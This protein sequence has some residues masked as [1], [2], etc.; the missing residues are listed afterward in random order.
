MKK[1][2]TLL[3]ACAAMCLNSGCA[4][5]ILGGAAGALGAYAISKDTIEGESDRP[6]KSLW[7]AAYKVSKIR[8]TISQEDDTRGYLELNADASKVDIRLIRL[9][10]ATTRIRIS[11]RKHHLPNLNLA[12]ELFIKIME[13][14]K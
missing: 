1:R 2:I 3:L 11:A 9:T 5:L 10:H 7:D 4:P 14:S 13:E 12:Q 6:Y 8:G